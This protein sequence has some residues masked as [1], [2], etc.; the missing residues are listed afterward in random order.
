MILLLNFFL[1]PTLLGWMFALDMALSAPRGIK[2]PA[3][4]FYFHG[5]AYPHDPDD[6]DDAPPFHTETERET[7]ERRNYEAMFPPEERGYPTHPGRRE[8]HF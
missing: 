4:A 7:R 3:G 6:P 1:T 2:Y 5:V 8:P